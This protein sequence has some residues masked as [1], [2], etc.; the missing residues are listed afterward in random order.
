MTAGPNPVDGPQ[1][2]MSGFDTLKAK[3]AELRKPKGDGEKISGPKASGILVGQ[4]SVHVY[5]GKLEEGLSGAAAVKE[6]PVEDGKLG[7]ALNQLLERGE[8][9]RNVVIG[10]DPT[11]DFLSTAWPDPQ[12]PHIF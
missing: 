7:P 2:T 3:L 4:R 12:N 8:I 10:L 1:T 5:A 6:Y 11:L 9:G